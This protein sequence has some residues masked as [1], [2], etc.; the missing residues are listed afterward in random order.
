M[1]LDDPLHAVDRFER[2]KVFVA[3]GTD[4]FASA[5]TLFAAGKNVWSKS[6][7]SAASELIAT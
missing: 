2:S 5:N 7:G 6:L 4:G 3:V 1:I